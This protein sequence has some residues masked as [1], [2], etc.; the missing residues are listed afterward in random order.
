MSDFDESSELSTGPLRVLANAV[1]N[2][3]TVL[4]S[5]RNNH[6]LV[7]KVKAFDR[8]CNMILEKVKELWHEQQGNN[9][10]LRERYVA[11]MFLRG[12]SVV[13]VLK[14]IPE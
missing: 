9:K 4:V 3:D 1:E 12:D 13:L 6:R 2:N 11:K 8:H 14:H 5:L 7:A 10:V